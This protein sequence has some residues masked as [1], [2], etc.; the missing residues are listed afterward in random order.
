MS[1]RQARLTN[2]AKQLILELG[3]RREL[4]SNGEEYFR[5]SRL[6]RLATERWLRRYRTYQALQEQHGVNEVQ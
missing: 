3:R 2:E 1:E 4:G 6:E 5:L